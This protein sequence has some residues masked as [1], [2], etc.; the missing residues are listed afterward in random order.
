MST[1]N[2]P[3]QHGSEMVITGQ[4]KSILIDWITQILVNIEKRFTHNSEKSSDVFLTY[5]TL[6]PR[7]ISIL[8]D[9]IGVLGMEPFQTP[10]KRIMDYINRYPNIDRVVGVKVLSHLRLYRYNLH[11]IATK[12]TEEVWEREEEQKNEYDETSI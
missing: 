8:N 4:D 12:E 7:S 2:N 10:V 9:C 11:Q 6:I 5:Y 3:T 1:T